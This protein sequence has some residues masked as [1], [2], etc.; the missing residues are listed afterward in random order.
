M[1]TGSGMTID[2]VVTTGSDT[3]GRADSTTGAAPGGAGAGAGSGG[4]FQR[5][6]G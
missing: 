3:T 2:S 4:G 5:S 1:T 6:V